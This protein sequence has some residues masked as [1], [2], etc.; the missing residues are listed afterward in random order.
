MHNTVSKPHITIIDDE[1]NFSESLQMAL[2]DSFEISMA[3]TIR[4]GRELLRERIPDAILLDMRLPD[5]EGIEFLQ[6]IRDIKPMPVIIVM[7]AYATVENAVAAL[8]EGAVDY[9]IKPLDIEKLKRAL[10]LYLENRVLH[11]KIAEMDKEIRKITHSFETA[12]TGR[13]KE[14][15]DR[16]PLIA[17]LDIPVLIRG[18]TGTGKEKL[19]R[20]IHSLS[21]L[22]G[23]LIA[24]NC[25]ALPK[26]II[27]C[28]LFGFTKGAFSGAGSY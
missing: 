22:Q 9:F 23:E 18:E 1:P 7:T 24:I 11:R 5:G 12:G 14:I 10:N 4:S 16:A 17:P 13:M 15:L 27:E 26:E 3:A 21:G 28:E 19:A 8:K 25:A 20:W 6:G 2:E